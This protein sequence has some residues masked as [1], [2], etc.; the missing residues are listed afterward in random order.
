MSN[1][2]FVLAGARRLHRFQPKRLESVRTDM[3]ISVTLTLRGK[4]NGP[5]VL[6]ELS[7]DVATMRR[8]PVAART[9]IELFS[10][11]DR[12]ELAVRRFAREHN[13]DF[14]TTGPSSIELHGTV[15]DLNPAFGVK[16]SHYAE[17][18]HPATYHAHDDEI[19]IPAYLSRIVT[20]VFG[21]DT[22][23]I[24]HRPG[25][26]HS[27]SALSISPPSVTAKTR[28][29]A[30]FGHLYNF[31]AQTTGRKQSIGLLEFGGGFRLS[32]LKAYF[33][34]VGAAFP[35]IVVKEIGRG[36]NRPCGKP[37]T[38]NPDTEVYMDIEVAGCLAP[39]ATLV[40]YFGEDTEQ[41]WLKTLRSAIFD[42][43]HDLSVI[44]IS[45]G[46]AEQDWTPRATAE[47]DRLFQV[48][49][50]R[51]ITICCSSGDN[52]V[53]E[54]SGHPFTVAFPATSPHVLA[55]GGTQLDVRRNGSRNETVWNQWRQYK[56]ASG[57]GVSQVF[58]L[59]AFQKKA[60]VPNSD[61]GG[62]RR[63]RGIPDVAANASSKTGYLIEA[64]RTRMSM[65]GTSAAAP[66]WAALVARLNEALGTKI[67]FITP[68]L[69]EMR[70]TTADTIC[71][72]VKGFNGPTRARGYQAKRGWDACTG[73]GSPDGEKILQWLMARQKK[74]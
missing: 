42:E 10:H 40:V 36:A 30:E 14:K 58:P 35:R 72:I 49:A 46:E 12:D 21:L 56:L 26:S 24:G 5:Q 7:N 69:Y 9:A 16:L 57:G 41:G 33:K 47:I 25:F 6:A 60:K 31:P 68:L 71:D 63:G 73:L 37:H 17:S 62:H 23:R 1:D 11:S 50:H 29:P 70:S 52:G 59:P 27:M 39:D 55:C 2:R 13:L 38:L 4:R 28:A 51:G 53:T 65:G 44:S 67:G 74:R 18:K 15:G 48:A 61:S 34:S 45:W 20:G 64:D 22:H 43:Q 8:K 54:L 66:L 3:E 32:E 19:T